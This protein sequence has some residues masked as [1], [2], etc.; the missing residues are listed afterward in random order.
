MNRSNKRMWQTKERLR[1][2]DR[3]GQSSL[4]NYRFRGES[5]VSPAP[6]AEVG[7]RSPSKDGPRHRF[8][9]PG[10]RHN[11]FRS[12]SAGRSDVAHHAKPEALHTFQETAQIYDQISAIS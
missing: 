9:G 7:G 6:L 10:T 12:L 3:V 5:L 1:T 11:G 2:T 4:T 8:L